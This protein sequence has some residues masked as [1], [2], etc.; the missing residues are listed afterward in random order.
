MANAEKKEARR[1]NCK[2][3]KEGHSHEGQPCKVG[4]VI[5]LPVDIADWLKGLK[6]VED[7]K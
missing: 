5:S 1:V 7:A 2:V 3:I 4:D 6:I